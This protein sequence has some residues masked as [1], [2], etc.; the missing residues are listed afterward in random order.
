MG[1]CLIT[2]R[3]EDFKRMTPELAAQILKE[4]TLPE[5]E[6]R[7][8]ANKLQA[9]ETMPGTETEDH[10][11]DAM[12]T[13]PNVNV[14]IMH[15]TSITFTLHGP[16]TAKGK[17]VTGT[18]HVSCSEGCIL[19]NGE[20]YSELIFTPEKPDSTFT[21]HGVSI[22]IGFHWERKED[23]T[24]AGSLRLIVE[25]DKVIAINTIPAED[26]LT[27]VISSEMRATSSL[28]LLKTHAIVSRSWLFS[29]ISRGNTTGGGNSYFSFPRKDG[30]HIR[31]YDRE[32]HTLFD[33]CADDHCQRYQGITRATNPAVRKA[34][35]ATRGMVL[36]SA[37]ELCD[38]RFSKC[39]GGVTEEYASCWEDKNM[40]YLTATRDTATETTAPRPHERGRGRTVDQ[41][42][43]G[44][45]LPHQQQKHAAPSAQRL[46]PRNQ[47]LLPLESGIHT[48]RNSSSHPRKTRR[49]FWRHR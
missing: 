49:R 26:Y 32:E 20:L 38:T 42:D 36:V 1:G 30:E 29:Q 28:E 45:I 41:V 16:F 2:P 43:T 47:R 14:G 25:D 19:W 5:T 12:V 13:E 10:T 24:F 33:V 35:E 37:G 3:A 18:G 22:G 34:V 23:E 48:S 11:L 46:R 27:S 44:I 40:P 7:R 4:V 17:S 15:D 9:P 21:L 6:V 8:I 31:W 39:C